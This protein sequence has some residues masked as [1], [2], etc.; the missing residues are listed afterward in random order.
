MRS[1]AS[2]RVT[3]LLV[4][5]ALAGCGSGPDTVYSWT[6]RTV[7]R[8]A[9]PGDTGPGDTG[10]AD[11][12]SGETGPGDTGP[13]D[14]GAGDRCTAIEWVSMPGGTFEMGASDLSNSTPVHSVAVSGF[15]MGRT[16]VTV[17]QYQACVNAATC[18]PP[19]S[20]CSQSGDA[21][22]VACTDWNPIWR[23]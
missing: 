10:P 2:V 23:W 19:S 5:W 14:T 18:A 3:L 12:G 13:G 8:E 7:A 20:L 17:C 16:E 1:E 21:Y 11:T 15:K 9:G 4:A 22:P 6:G